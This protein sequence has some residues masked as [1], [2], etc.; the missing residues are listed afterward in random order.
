MDIM[1]KVLNTEVKLSQ[2]IVGK[3]MAKAADKFGNKNKRLS[4]HELDQ[5][6]KSSPGSVKYG[7]TDHLLANHLANR[8]YKKLVFEAIKQNDF[9]SADK[10]GNRIKKIRKTLGGGAGN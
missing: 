10:I 4:I 5:F 7:P 2:L 1:K 8:V 6:I 3:D 9:V